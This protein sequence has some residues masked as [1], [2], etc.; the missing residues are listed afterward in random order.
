MQSRMD[1]QMGNQM[2][3]ENLQEY[4]VRGL[5]LSCWLLVSNVGPSLMMGHPPV[6]LGPSEEEVRYSQYAPPELPRF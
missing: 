6:T 2:E 4:R 3:T 1:K 5:G